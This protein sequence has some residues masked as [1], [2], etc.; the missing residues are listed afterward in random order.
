MPAIT[1]DAPAQT[2]IAAS[3]TTGV[4]SMT[5]VFPDGEH[6]NLP[7]STHGTT[8]SVSPAALP[9]GISTLTLDNTNNSTINITGTA[10]NNAGNL[11]ISGFNLKFD[12]LPPSPL[13]GAVRWTLPTTFKL[14]LNQVDNGQYILANSNL[15]I[16]WDGVTSVPPVSPGQTIN[17]T[18]ELYAANGTLEATITHQ[19]VVAAD[20]KSATFSGNY[21]QIRFSRIAFSLDVS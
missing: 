19:A 10:E 12:V 11:A 21:S 4:P 15:T 13:T 1:I 7:L 16:F 20:G 6:G 9:A 18:V 2:I 14:N 5:M 8:E 17:G 3:S